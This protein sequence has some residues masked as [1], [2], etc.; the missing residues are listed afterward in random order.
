MQLERLAIVLRPRH[1]NEAIDLGVRM[2]MHWFKPLYGAW[3][4]FTLPVLAILFSLTYWSSNSYLL[5]YLL[6]WWIKPMFDRIALFVISRAVFGDAPTI[7]QSMRAIPT[8]LFKT[9]LF[10]ALTWARFTPYRSLTLPVDVLEGVKGRNARIRRRSIS[11][12]I[13]INAI[14]LT[15]YGIIIEQIFPICAMAFLAML[16]IDS[17]GFSDDLFDTLTFNDFSY[18]SQLSLGLY[19]LGILLWEPIYVAAGFSLYLKRRSDIEAWDI[20]LQFRKTEKKR[21]STTSSLF[22]ALF[23]VITFGLMMQPAPSYAGEQSL[24]QEAIIQAPDRLNNILQQSEY[25]GKTTEKSLKLSDEK[26]KPKKEKTKSPNKPTSLNTGSAF[27]GVANVGQGFLWFVL[28]LAI[29]VIVYLI[30]IR[31]PVIQTKRK[32]SEKPPAQIAGLDIQPESLPENI[33]EVALAMIRSGDL[34]SALSLLFRG[35]L[36]VLAHRDR[37]L[38]RSSDTEQDCIR[39]VKRANL[40]SSAFFIQLTQLWLAQAYAHRSPDLARLEQLCLEWPTHYDHQSQWEAS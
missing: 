16:S 8:L 24:R 15:L 18:L 37:V 28:A 32:T 21:H 27:N 1:A 3:F 5:L 9:R 14:I 39:L 38:F 7:R 13:G 4:C 30:I 35:S 36:S 2:A 11:S 20:E 26:E 10:R 23:A 22:G 29:A 34:R 33:A 31:L 12:Y 25:G 19:T 17:N 6:V 40:S